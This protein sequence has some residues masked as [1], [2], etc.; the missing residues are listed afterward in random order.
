MVCSLHIIVIT[1]GGF[2]DYGTA[3]LRDRHIAVI[4]RNAVFLRKPFRDWQ[5]RSVGKYR[6][7]NFLTGRIWFSHQCIAINFST[8]KQIAGFDKV[9]R[10]ITAYN[11]RTAAPAASVARMPG[12][13]S[14]IP[15]LNPYTDR[16]W[17]PVLQRPCRA[18]TGS[19]RYLRRCRGSHWRLHWLAW[20]VHCRWFVILIE[21][22]DFY[23][24]TSLYSIV[25]LSYHVFRKISIVWKKCLTFALGFGI[26]LKLSLRDKRKTEKFGLER[27]DSSKKN[28]KKVLDKRFWFWYTK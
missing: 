9:G 6:N 17:K 15:G 22:R 14:E 7:G 13:V 23:G 2:L 24:I 11:A 21:N 25:Q 18:S 16:D 28:L 26:L 12:T 20:T 4:W 8:E 27:L 10:C 19:T 3:V 1:A 5:A